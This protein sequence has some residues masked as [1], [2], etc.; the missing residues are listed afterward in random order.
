MQFIG[1][2]NGPVNT[3]DMA[4][5]LQKYALIICLPV[6]PFTP[7]SAQN[8]NSRQVPNFILQNT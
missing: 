5:K 3:R 8:E 6:N 1:R 7:K 2:Q 4:L